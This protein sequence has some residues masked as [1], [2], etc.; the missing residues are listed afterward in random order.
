MEASGVL[1][2]S[3]IGSLEDVFGELCG[4]HAAPDEAEEFTPGFE[5]IRK[6]I[7]EGWRL[8]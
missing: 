2:G 5:Q 6:R 1:D 4:R 7:G 3:Q 8:R